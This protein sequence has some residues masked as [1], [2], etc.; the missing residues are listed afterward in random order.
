M[1]AVWRTGG[2]MMLLLVS[3]AETSGF[4][5][6]DPIICYILDGAL[7]FYSVIATMLFFKIK[8]CKTSQTTEPVPEDT[9]AQLKPGAHEEYEDL[10]TATATRPMKRPGASSDTYQTLQVTD[11]ANDAYQVITSKGKGRK[12]K[13]KKA[14]D[15]QHVSEENQPI[16]SPPPL[17]PH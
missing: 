4:Q 8:W 15:P 14:Q 2:V 10:K 12:K 6:T 1:A 11:D 13:E 9:Y 17:P 5:M 16:E 7:L 3:S